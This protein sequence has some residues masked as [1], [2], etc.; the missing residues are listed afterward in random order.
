M[1]L[2]ANNMK[3]VFKRQTAHV[4][5]H[6]PSANMTWIM[7]TGGTASTTMAGQRR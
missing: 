4:R 2:G 3:D 1:N 5:H 6:P 7:P